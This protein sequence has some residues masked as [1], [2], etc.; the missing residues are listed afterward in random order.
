MGILASIAPYGHF[1]PI[2]MKSGFFRRVLNFTKY[3][4]LLP[5]NRISL[6]AERFYYEEYSHYISPYIIKGHTLL[7]AGCGMGRFTI[8]AALAGM[9][10]TAT[11]V[12]TDHFR[13]ISRKIDGRGNV[14]FRHETLEK[15]LKS[16]PQQHFDVILCLGLLHN[17]P[18]PQQN[19]K[20]LSLLLRPGGVLITSHR[21]PGYYLFRYIRERNFDA[22]R[23]FSDA[24]HPDYNAQTSEDLMEM[25]RQS[26]LELIKLAPIGLFSG[27][28]SDAFS[29]IANPGKMSE[30]EKQKLFSLEIHPQLMQLFANSARYNLMIAKRL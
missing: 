2:F 24:N 27:H 17:L 13:H 6:K 26:G 12:R 21:S 8:P 19:I 23:R 4:L 9:K 20:K 7:D 5:H 14:E 28:G 25:C 15:S 10:V 3:R 1:Y 18:E 30:E 16:L 29:G 11:N 22:A